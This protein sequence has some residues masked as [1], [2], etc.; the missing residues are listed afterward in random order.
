MLRFILFSCWNG[1]DFINTNCDTFLSSLAWKGFG[2]H[3]LRCILSNFWHDA[4]LDNTCLDIFYVFSG[5]GHM[6]R[7]IICVFGRGLVNWCLDT[8]SIEVV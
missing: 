5:M 2:Q 1:R 7:C 3:K 8:F 6:L 4:G